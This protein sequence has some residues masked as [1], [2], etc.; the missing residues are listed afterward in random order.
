VQSG[1]LAWKKLTR[2]TQPS[3]QR[4]TGARVLQARPPRLRPLEDSG[5]NDSPR[6][7]V[8]CGAERWH[9]QQMHT[10]ALPSLADGAPGQ[11]RGCCNSSGSAGPAWPS[12]AQPRPQPTLPPPP[13]CLC[14]CLEPRMNNREGAQPPPWIKHASRAPSHVI[15]WPQPQPWSRAPALARRA[16]AP[17]R[18][19]RAG[20]AAGQPQ[21][22]RPQ[23]LPP[24]TAPP[25]CR[26]RQPPGCRR[27]AAGAAE[28]HSRQNMSRAHRVRHPARRGGA[29][30]A[31]VSPP[32][33]YPVAV[34]KRACSQNGLRNQG[35][36]VN[37]GS[38]ASTGP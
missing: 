26:Q 34:E 23:A 28:K 12:L 19:A 25:G 7:D 24:Q 32:L 1:P 37:T 3:S 38:S 21:H 22:T 6:Y 20:S 33:S 29:A 4:L 17:R 11:R 18:A 27:L 30:A 35:T 31:A 8:R 9:Q 10:A 2:H 13:P 16:A 5:C 36:V 14:P 15:V